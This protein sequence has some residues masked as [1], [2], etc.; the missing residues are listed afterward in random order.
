[1]LIGVPDDGKVQIRVVHIQFEHKRL[2]L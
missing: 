1:L 2:G